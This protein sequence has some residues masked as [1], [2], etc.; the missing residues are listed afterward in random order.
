MTSEPQCANSYT[1]RTQPSHAWC[2]LVREGLVAR[3]PAETLGV[4]GVPAD[5]LGWQLMEQAG[6]HIHLLRPNLTPFAHSQVLLCEGSASTNGLQHLASPL[7]TGVF[8]QV[9]DC[10]AII[11]YIS[12]WWRLKLYTPHTYMMWGYERRNHISFVLATRRIGASSNMNNNKL[13]AWYVYLLLLFY[14]HTH[15]DASNSWLLVD[16]VELCIIIIYIM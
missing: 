14:M 9:I 6:W 8:T 7:A 10:W 2:T 16:R 4:S 1:L 11:I 12:Q 5:P 3:V 15:R 13:I